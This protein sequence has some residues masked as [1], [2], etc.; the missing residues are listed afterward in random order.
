MLTQWLIDRAKR[1]PYFHLE[2]YMNRWWLV[3]YGEV[4]ERR[5]TCERKFVFMGQVG[6]EGEAITVTDGTGPVTW[7][8]PIA[9]LLQKLGIAVRVHEILRSDAG[10]DPHDH[11]WPYLTV[12]LRGGYFETRY[13][14]EGFVTGR[15]W[16]GPGSVMF[17]P[18]KSWHRLDVPPGTTAT[19][20]FI[21][22]PKAQ[23][24]GF[25]VDGVKVPYDQYKERV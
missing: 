16:H 6:V 1:T 20:L 5:I 24:W 18:A 25:N 21:T 23:R 3:P 17:R 11:P 10:R 13:D 14:D 4:I 9:R 2:G 8:R 19:T 12:I 7:R 22:G 15:K